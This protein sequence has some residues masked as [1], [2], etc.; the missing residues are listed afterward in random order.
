MEVQFVLTP[1]SHTGSNGVMLEFA[2]LDR[3]NTPVARIEFNRIPSGS[4]GVYENLGLGCVQEYEVRPLLTPWNITTSH[5]NITIIIQV[6]VCLSMCVWGLSFFLKVPHHTP[7]SPLAYKKVCV[8]GSLFQQHHHNQIS[9]CVR[10]LFLFLSRH[11][12]PS[13]ICV[14]FGINI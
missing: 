1:P 10:E 13:I 14:H 2:T 3:N 7:T 9:V 8:C 11:H 12:I 6:S 4:V 5:T